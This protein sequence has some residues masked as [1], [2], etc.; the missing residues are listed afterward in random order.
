M[1]SSIP[2]A[3]LQNN[4]EQVTHI[5]LMDIYEINHYTHV[6]LRDLIH[7]QSSSN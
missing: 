2:H 5:S 6:S 1:F 4:D 3:C 7:E